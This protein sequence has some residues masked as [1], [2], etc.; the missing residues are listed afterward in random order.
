[1]RTSVNSKIS[2]TFDICKYIYR[3]YSLTLTL[4]KLLDS[5]FENILDPANL[6]EEDAARNGTAVNQKTLISL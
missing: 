3:V 4:R 5:N 2:K 6:T 1:M